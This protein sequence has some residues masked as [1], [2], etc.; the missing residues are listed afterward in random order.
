[1]QERS[2]Q[3]YYRAIQSLIAKK[4]EFQ[5][6]KDLFIH[7]WTSYLVTWNNLKHK[8][9]LQVV[10]TGLSRQM[11]PSD[12]VFDMFLCLGIHAGLF[13]IETYWGIDIDES[14][15][16]FS[17]KLWKAMNLEFVPCM[18]TSCSLEFDTACFGQ[19]PCSDE[20]LVDLIYLDS[21]DFDWMLGG[22]SQEHQLKEVQK[23]WPHLCKGGIMLLDDIG[24]EH[25][26]KGGMAIPWLLEQ[27]DAELIFLDYQAVFKKKE[28]VDG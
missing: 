27:P 1:M 19:D 24:L 25:G 18:K 4:P 8:N 3:E 14:A 28:V 17:Q 11:K 12:G 10:Q 20:P 2:G 13:D 6:Y 9:H 23:Y 16:D 15:V 26:G 21:W 7:R 5:V 22:P